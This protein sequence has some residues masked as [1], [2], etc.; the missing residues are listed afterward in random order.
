MW[1]QDA[2]GSTRASEAW[3]E[4]CSWS[5]A[6]KTLLVTVARG[7]SQGVWGRSPEL[8]KMREMSQEAWLRR[9]RVIEQEV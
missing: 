8:L 5:L 6:A 1:P 9:R 3:S 2:E 4:I 7:V